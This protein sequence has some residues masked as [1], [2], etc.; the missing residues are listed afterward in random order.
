MGGLGGLGVRRGGRIRD[1]R[2]G[3]L[4]LTLLFLP[5]WILLILFL[6]FFLL[7]DRP[8]LAIQ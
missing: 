8:L 3:L 7:V 2:V 6:S 5:I 4:R 1:L